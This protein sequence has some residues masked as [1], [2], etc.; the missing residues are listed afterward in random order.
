[1]LCSK[2]NRGLGKGERLTRHAEQQELPQACIVQHRKLAKVASDISL[3]DRSRIGLIEA[4]SNII[5]LNLTA[6][7]QAR[8][9]TPLTP[10]P[11]PTI[12]TYTKPNSRGR[13]TRSPLIPLWLLADRGGELGDLVDEGEDGWLVGRYEGCV[14][15]GAAVGE[16]PFEE[17]GGGGLDDFAD[18]VHA[19]VGGVAWEGGV[20]WGV[21][22]LVGINL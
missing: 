6:S 15:G 2:R 18:P 11:L 8:H 19:A 4:I 14:D 12:Q 9:I 7:A 21:C 16:V 20:A 1:M 3:Q 10:S 17:A 13:I 22:V 5:D